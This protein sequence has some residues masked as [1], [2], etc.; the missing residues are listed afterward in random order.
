LKNYS[1]PDRQIQRPKTEL[2]S[3]FQR[4]LG[5]TRKYIDRNHALLLA[6]EIIDWT[7]LRRSA[8]F[9]RFAEKAARVKL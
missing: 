4:E 3:L 8:S 2:I 5:N 6:K 9:C 1:K 7:K